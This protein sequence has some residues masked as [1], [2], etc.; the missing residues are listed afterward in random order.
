MSGETPSGGTPNRMN[1]SLGSVLIIYHCVIKHPKLPGISNQHLIMLM[2]SVGQEFNR[3][4]GV[5][6]GGVECLGS[7]CCRQPPR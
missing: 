6:G 1:N 4:P 7:A 3:A 2:D 5:Q